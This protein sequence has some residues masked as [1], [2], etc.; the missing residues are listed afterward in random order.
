MAR[1]EKAAGDMRSQLLQALEE[2]HR[3]GSIYVSGDLPLIL[4][5]LEVDKVGSIRLPLDA[6]QARRL[7]KQMVG[8]PRNRIRTASSWVLISTDSIVARGARERTSSTAA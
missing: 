1:T 7:I 2:I 6:A 4:P 5:G 8:D 3:P